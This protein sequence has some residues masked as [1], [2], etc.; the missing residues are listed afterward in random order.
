[1][2][3]KAHCVLH[4]F[5]MCMKEALHHARTLWIKAAFSALS[6]SFKQL[7]LLLNL[8]A[9]LLMADGLLTATYVIMQSDRY[10]CDYVITDV[11]AVWAI[12]FNPRLAN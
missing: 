7:L 10:A 5:F 12:L 1:M 3:N 2:N 9:I 6:S 8:D 4:G 11:Y